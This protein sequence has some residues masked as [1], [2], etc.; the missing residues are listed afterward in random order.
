MVTPCLH[1]FN[2]TPTWGRLHEP[3]F[4]FPC[5]G[6]L[7]QLLYNTPGAGGLHA[8]LVI[9]P[10]DKLPLPVGNLLPDRAAPDVDALGVE[11]AG[12]SD[13]EPL[14]VLVHPGDDVD[15]FSHPR[16]P[17]TGSRRR[18]APRSDQG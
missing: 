10:L 15:Q 13:L 14:P 4:L 18:P 17:R 2:Y 1:L 6:T 5:R 9:D 16:T 11:Q 8:R 12:G 7:P 3:R